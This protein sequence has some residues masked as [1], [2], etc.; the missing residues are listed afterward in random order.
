MVCAGAKW[1]AH[2]NV[3]PMHPGR[4]RHL[5]RAPLPETG[6]TRIRVVSSHSSTSE[7]VTLPS[8]LILAHAPHQNPLPDFRH[9]PIQRVFAGCYEPLLKVGGSRRYLHNLCMGAWSRTP[10]RSPGAVTRSFP[11]DI[12]LTHGKRRSA[13]EIV[14]AMRLRQGIT[15]EAADIRLPSGSHAR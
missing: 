10:P 4:A 7:G 8:S 1:I 9:C 6:V 14:P 2:F 11:G 12:G 3:Q 13:R 5:P 15:F